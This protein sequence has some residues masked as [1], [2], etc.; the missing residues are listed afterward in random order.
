MHIR[1]TVLVATLTAAPAASAATLPLAGEIVVPRVT[2]RSAPASNAP[3]VRVL[4]EFRPDH[5]PQLVLALDA[6]IGPGGGLWYRLS[7]PGR[8]NGERGWVPA[9]ALRLRQL[10]NRI[11]VR[12]GARRLEV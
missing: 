1:L 11:V 6:R 12:R 3:A 5:R 10:A 7:L 4:R 2:A 9:Q 8:P